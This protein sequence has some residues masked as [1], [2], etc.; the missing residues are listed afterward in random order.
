MLPDISIIVTCYNYGQYLE[1][2]LRSLF[3]QHYCELFSFEV[4]VVD[5]FSNDCTGSIC[6]KFLH[7]FNNLVY[8]RNLKNLGL[9]ASCNFGINMSNG[10]YI[11]RV[12]ADDYVSRNFMFFLKYALDK[13]RKFQAFA[14]DY[15][16]VDFFENLI[17]QV[18]FIDEQIACGVM[19]R[20]EFL[21]D[22]GLYNE[23]FE[24]REGHE[25]N[26][27]FSEKYKIGILPIPL[28]FARKHNSNRSSNLDKIEEY[29]NKLN[30]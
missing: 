12:D 3:N 8:F 7:K 18:S 27:R 16:E 6:N 15:C 9:Q 4:I 14:C 29:D 11:V 5:D 2:C 20:K 25:L 17:K 19:Y 10:R 13:N 26:K 21:L 30:A 22:V 23:K 24:Y 1:R 28:Y